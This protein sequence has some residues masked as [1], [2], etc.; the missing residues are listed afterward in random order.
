M[1]RQVDERLGPSEYKTF[2]KHI[3]PEIIRLEQSDRNY[4]LS[5]RS[6]NINT[7]QHFIYDLY[8]QSNHVD[9]GIKSYSGVM[10]IIMAWEANVLRTESAGRARD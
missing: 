8:L 2:I 6:P 7:T 1:L 10:A 9:G 3:R 4:W 5:R